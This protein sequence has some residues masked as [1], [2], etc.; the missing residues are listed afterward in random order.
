MQLLKSSLVNLRP[1]ENNNSERTFVKEL[2]KVDDVK[3]YYVLRDDHAADLDSFVSYMA[4]CNAAQRG[5]YCIIELQDTTQVGLITAEL[6]RDNLSGSIMWNV[7]YAVAPAYRRKRYAYDALMYLIGILQRFTIQ[8]IILD[9]SE[10]NTASERLAEKCGF[11]RMVSQTGG[12]IGFSDF[13]HM[14]LGTRYRWIRDTHSTSKRDRLNIEAIKCHRVKN[15]LKAIELYKQSLQEPYTAGSVFNDGTVYANLG[16]SYSS[17]RMYQEAYNSLTKAWSLGVK[18][19][20][21]QK[22][23]AWL[24]DHA[25]IG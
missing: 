9:I 19:A 3:K 18:N 23:L 10:S 24:R 2:F 21:V 22:E 7:G 15:Y 14:D 25:G 13:E 8:Y 4:T 16:M 5:L 17:A 12:L 6:V 20:T 11:K 1:I